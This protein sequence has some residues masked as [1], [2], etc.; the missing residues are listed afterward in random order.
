MMQIPFGSLPGTSRLFQDYTSDWD[1]VRS[2]YD[3]SYRFDSILTFARKRLAEPLPHR[4]LLCRSLAAL[5]RKWGG[6]AAVVA[7]LE[8]GAIAVVAGQQPGLF[9]GSLYSILKAVTAIKLA[10]ALREAGVPAVP[11]FWVGAEDHDYE[12]IRWASVLDK[13]STLRR[14]SVDL[15]NEESSPVGWLAFKQDV[16]SAVAECLSSLPQ[17]EFQA[18]LGD[19]LGSAYRPGQSPVDSFAHMMVRLFGPDGLIVVDPL[20]AT[21]KSIAEPLLEQVAVRNGEIR[22]AVLARSAAVSASGYHQQVKV[23]QN[24]TGLFALRGRSRQALRRGDTESAS[25]PLSPN[26]L[27]RPVV[28]DTI[29]PT[30]AFVAGP[31]EIAY[32]AQAGA[33]YHVFGRET[34]PIYPRISATFLETRVAKALRKYDIQF[35]DVFQGKEFLKRRAVENAQGGSAFLDAKQRIEETLESLR[36]PLRSVDPTLD[37]A[38]DTAKQKMLYHIETLETKFINAETRRNEVMDRQ[39]ELICTA[40]FPEKKLQERQLNVATFIARY[41]M[42]FIRGL[43]D[44]LSLDSTQHQV[45]DL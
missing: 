13:D 20:D 45:I 23:D 34:T 30:A 15:A 11:L 29:L 36:G 25:A 40:L 9:T 16:Q 32:L 22:A 12:E 26:V 24:F 38:V 35:A 4:E 33:V 5:Q 1:K 28:Q 17:S 44:S 10:R 37:G 39:L 42:N 14:I 6:D 27:V 41:G 43:A 8:K 31:A 3:H 19:I 7:D 2:L 21:L 18:E